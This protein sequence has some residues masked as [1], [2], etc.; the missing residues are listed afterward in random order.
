VEL[1]QQ[2]SLIARLL[3]A[4]AASAEIAAE[5]VESAVL[6]EELA[7]LGRA[8]AKRTAEFAAGRACAHVAMAKLG[9]ED[10]PL[11][12]GSR[13]EPLW[14][15]GVV[16]SITHCR[17]YVAAAVA[18]AADLSAIG[19]DAEP[20]ESLPPGV[21]DSVAS[22]QEQHHLRHLPEGI[23]WGRVL[24][25]AKESIYKAWFPVAGTWLGF[26]QADLTIDP[27]AHTFR[28]QLIDAQ[29]EIG[30]VA[31]R[32]IEGRFLLTDGHILTAVTIAGAG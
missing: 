25:S 18:R 14:P 20:H 30:G 27:Q 9:V 12:R 6:P 8:V 4:S 13:R 32:Q 22:A 3:P 29:L 2:P 17:G 31:L 26:E 28:A 23:H 24:F 19:I 1:E 16:G 21:L 7:S 10:R 15:A 5:A 11:L